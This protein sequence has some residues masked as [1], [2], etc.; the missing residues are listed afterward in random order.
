M[1]TDLLQHELA[2]TSAI[3]GRQSSTRVVF[4]GEGAYTDGKTI[5][6]PALPSMEEVSDELADVMRGYADHEAG[7]VRH[8]DFAAIKEIVEESNER[9]DPLLRTLHNALEDIWLERLVRQEYPGSE[10]LL[11]ATANA[12]N[13]EFLEG[14]RDGRLDMEQVQK[15]AFI[16]PVAITWEGRKAYASETVPD[17]LAVISERLR[18]ALPVWVAGLDECKSS[19]DV[20]DLAR[21]VDAEIREWSKEDEREP[22]ESGSGES[23]EGGEGGEEPEDEEEWRDHEGGA[24]EGHEEQ[25]EE[26]G[27]E[28]AEGEGAGGEGSEEGEG[29][30]T[31]KGTAGDGL[32]VGSAGS[33]EF[34][35]VYED[36]DLG[37]LVERMVRKEL[38]EVGGAYRPYS[39]EK[40]EWHHRKGD[41]R[42][43]VLIRIGTA[44]QYDL[45]LRGMTGQVNV[46]RRGLERALVSQQ[47]RDWAFGLE[48]GRLDSKRFVAAVAGRENVFKDRTDREELDTA[49]TFL[50]DLS[51]SMRGAPVRCARDCVIAFSEALDRTSVAYEVLGWNNVGF[52]DFNASQMASDHDQSWGRYD[53]LDMY[54]F[55]AFQERLFD[56]KGAI[57]SMVGCAEGNNS[58]GDAVWQAYTRLRERPRAGRSC[59]C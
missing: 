25:P 24:G 37:K 55:K 42:R 52:P 47:R 26:G 36:F 12:V 34:S 40:D 10:R 19:F 4:K 38:G 20:A 54:V 18:E 22:S 41:T 49:V 17:C 11:R 27:D 16:A 9:G 58:D 53:V 28:D 39:T 59:S 21:K 13:R 5:V 56:A 32:A 51:G 57:A 14:L 23:G 35:E 45:H 2:Q 50:V 8:S 1:K 44:E 30:D 15:D 33:D 43:S 6:L 3:F 31:G 46:L 48:S 29:S 7:H